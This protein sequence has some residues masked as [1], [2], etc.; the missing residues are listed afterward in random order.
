MYQPFRSKSLNSKCQAGEHKY[1]GKRPEIED[2][3][4]MF[5][6][7]KKGNSQ[8]VF[9]CGAMM[10][11]HYS[12]IYLFSCGS[13]Y[14][15]NY[16]IRREYNLNIFNDAILVPDIAHSNYFTLVTWPIAQLN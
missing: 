13:V 10:F 9:V 5:T 15:Y 1:N 4:L 6:L 16:I 12:P 8:N 7:Y 3:K 2:K 11:L 14:H